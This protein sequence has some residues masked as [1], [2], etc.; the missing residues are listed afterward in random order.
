MSYRNKNLLERIAAIQN[1]VLEYK[2]KGLS[3]V[4]VYRHVVKGRFFISEA[5]FKKYMSRN[6]KLEL[7]KLK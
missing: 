5:T 2:S 7:K 3:Q 6:A 4:W 1:V